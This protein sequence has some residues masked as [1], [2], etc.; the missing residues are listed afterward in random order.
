M[1]RS[2]PRPSPG[3]GCGQV[4]QTLFDPAIEPDRECRRTRQRWQLARGPARHPMARRSAGGQPFARKTLKTRQI[5]DT[6]GEGSR[7]HQHRPVRAAV[8]ADGN[9]T[10]ARPVRL[11]GRRLATGGDSS[12][13]GAHLNCRERELRRRDDSPPIV[14]FVVGGQ[15]LNLRDR[16]VWTPNAVIR[17]RAVADL[18]QE[19]PELRRQADTEGRFYSRNF[20][21]TDRSTLI[22]MLI[23]SKNCTSSITSPDLVQLIAPGRDYSNLQF[24]D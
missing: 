15:T 16:C 5:P 8:M 20:R 13:N 21:Q 4:G 18:S 2:T 22:L 1:V 3:A 12:F 14:G 17:P 11:E 19:F 24:Y 6:T 7:H 9:A 10:A 23:R